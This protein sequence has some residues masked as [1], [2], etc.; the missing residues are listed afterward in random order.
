MFVSAYHEIVRVSDLHACMHAAASTWQGITSFTKHSSAQLQQARAMI[1]TTTISLSV[2][3]ARTHARTQADLPAPQYQIRCTSLD[4]L[5]A[6][7]YSGNLKSRPNPSTVLTT[8]R[9]PEQRLILVLVLH[10]HQIRDSRSMH[11][12][13]YVGVFPKSMTTSAAIHSR[14]SKLQVPRANGPTYLIHD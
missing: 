10:H 12:V 1:I 14:K 13:L 4:L 9:S 11:Q 7:C 5:T 8:S 3:Q 2:N 6:L